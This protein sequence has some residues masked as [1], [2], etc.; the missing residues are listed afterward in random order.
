MLVPFS[1]MRC[2]GPVA[3]KLTIEGVLLWREDLDLGEMR[4]EMGVAYLRLEL[5]NFLQDLGQ[6]F[7]SDRLGGEQTVELTLLVDERAA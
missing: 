5:G 4:L 1:A 2:R 6:A 7:G 3:T